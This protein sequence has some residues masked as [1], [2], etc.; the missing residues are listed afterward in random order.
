MK[1][2]LSL[3]SLL[4]L[5]LIGGA[6][7]AVADYYVGEQVS[8]IEL[9]DGDL[10]IFEAGCSSANYGR[11][12]T[13]GT[14]TDGRELSNRSATRIKEGLTEA[15]VWRVISANGIGRFY[16]QSVSSGY[17]YSKGS[18]LGR[19]TDNFS[20]AEPLQ[21][22]VF[23][24][25]TPYSGTQR[26][27]DYSG[28]PAG[29]NA[30]STALQQTNNSYYLCS[31]NSD[32]IYGDHSHARY[33]NIFRVS[34]DPSKGTAL[35]AYDG[36]T[37]TTSG[38]T[39]DGLTYDL[40]EINTPSGNV[41]KLTNAN[42]SYSETTLHIPAT[43]THEGKTYRVN[44]LSNGAFQGATFS[45]LEF[46]SPIF[47]YIGNWA[48]AECN[49]VTEVVVPEGITFLA[50]D[51]S[52]SKMNNL[53]TVT[54]PSTIRAIEN[55]SFASDPNL[56]TLI[57]KGETPPMFKG[58]NLFGETTV[59]GNITIVVP[60]EAAVAAYT[61]ALASYPVK[62]II[63]DP[64]ADGKLIT[65]LSQ[66][67][68]DKYYYIIS[69]FDG[70]RSLGNGGANAQ[71]YD[72]KEAALGYSTKSGVSGSLENVVS[73]V[74]QKRSEPDVNVIWKII[75]TGDN[76]ELQNIGSGK[77]VGSVVENNRLGWT[78]TFEVAQQ[79]SPDTD[80]SFTICNAAPASNTTTW[81]IQ[82][83]FHNNTADF[84][85][86]TTGANGYESTSGS[87]KAWKIYELSDAQVKKIC[88]EYIEKLNL[89]VNAGVGV[90]KGMKDSAS[91][92][93]ALAVLSAAPDYASLKD[94]VNNYILPL[95][96]G[97]YRIK[98]PKNYLGICGEPYVYFGNDLKLSS[99]KSEEA[100]KADYSTVYAINVLSDT[101]RYTV[102]NNVGDG[103]E[104]T[105]VAQG[106]Y[107]PYYSNSYTVQKEVTADNSNVK[108][109][110]FQPI[111][112]FDDN[113]IGAL[114]IDVTQA[115]GSYTNHSLLKTSDAVD[116]AIKANPPRGSGTKWPK[117]QEAYIEPATDIT[118]K[119]NKVG[120]D[121]WA[122]LYVPFGVTLPTGSEAF[123]GVVDGDVLRLTSIGQDI[124]AATPVVIVGDDAS[125]TATINDEI[126]AYTG[127][128]ALSGQYLAA[129]SR[130]DNIRS[131][132]VKDGVI[133]FYKL[134]TASTGLGANKAFLNMSS[135]SQGLKV[136]LDDDV[137]AVNTAIVNDQSSMV[138]D[139]YDLQGRKVVAPQKGS[140]YIKDG[141]VV[142][143]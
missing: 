82:G 137:T 22:H 92:T 91:K 61:T 45:S 27:N 98:F 6:N 125:I 119:M 122:T 128:N 84:I 40:T 29:W 80:G 39:I 48:F 35:S 21:T 14:V 33:W 102:N 18:D 124:P 126:A 87:E 133:G 103:Y 120:D 117:G 123:V 37:T 4:A 41:A 67:S 46:D 115:N 42:R 3:F 10:V 121:Y 136:V 74:V 116:N 28:N 138:N 49:N 69:Q 1:K 100:A 59:P 96:N 83:G 90:V 2:I 15:A 43:V 132:G 53:E 12:L 44:K 58:D 127:T 19:M 25:A 130:D 47:F 104:V 5:F 75:K 38:V 72:G 64:N 99:N 93:A 113:T 101:Y 78:N 111:I 106:G 94:A 131:L 66:I 70:F 55:Y 109:H 16:L 140:L 73:W 56:T 107:S 77:Y 143:F 139:Y 11:Y 62:E 32:M 118:I 97:Y 20:S 134:P 142:K 141:K 50:S 30:K 17:Y 7:N 86:A 31:D 65:N 88:E 105:M 95:T 23:P 112:G 114:I 79:I 54:L 9:E 129:S 60:S 108:A 51:R 36:T 13:D 68:D 57:F 26:F 76:Y 89:A 24:D 135:G 8:P 34:T 81:R 63:V 110:V 52:F 71:N 85:S